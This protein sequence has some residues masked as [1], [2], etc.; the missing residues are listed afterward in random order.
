MSGTITPPK[1]SQNGSKTIIGPIFLH[2]Q[3]NAVEESCKKPNA[4]ANGLAVLHFVGHS[5]VQHHAGKCSKALQM[6]FFCGFP[7]GVDPTPPQFLGKLDSL[8]VKKLCNVH[9]SRL[10]LELFY[11]RFERFYFVDVSS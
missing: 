5:P 11:T 6:V 4:G 1:P 8:F 10:H 7:F 3:G 2:S 9:R